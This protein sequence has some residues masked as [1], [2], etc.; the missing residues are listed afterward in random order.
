MILIR[1]ARVLTMIGP[2]SPPPGVA[3]RGRAMSDLGVLPRA[4]VM[5]EGDRILSVTPGPGSAPGAASRASGR[6]INAAGRVLM[7]GFIDAHTHALWAGDRLDEWE[8]KR[9][10]A[11][12]LDILKA[13]GGIMATVRAV[14]AASEDELA[15]GLRARLA[16]MLR[17]GTTTV[18]VKTGYGLSAEAELKMLRV[19]LGAARHAVTGGS[20]MPSA[21]DE[22]RAPGETRVE[23]GPR[24]M[25]SPAVGRPGCGAGAA[26]P[27][28]VP[29]ALLGHAIDPGRDR[30]EFIDEMC[31]PALDAAHREAP[32]AAVDA[33]CE[34]GAWTMDECVRLFERAASLGHPVRVH[35]D[36][37]HALGMT[38][39]AVDHGAR[40][41]DHLEAST[42][43]TLARLGR[44]ATIG[45]ALPCAGFHT[46]GRY[47]NARAII[48][49]G[50][51]VVLATN[52][53]PGSAPCASMP[54]AIALAV[55]HCGLSPAEAIVACSANA[56][57]LLGFADRGV[58]APGM[59]ADMILL[60]HDD[61]RLLACEF[62]G[63]PV[64]LV[65]RGGEIIGHQPG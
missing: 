44:S 6:V 21:P 56:A 38:D 42:P 57:A 34:D 13:G 26:L 39:W 62:G 28:V 15:R 23:S 32:H 11:S 27:A 7:P 24:T 17:E 54:M 33:Y 64:D 41:A 3:R 45:V 36:Q 49:A 53:N 37:F 10:G 4:D 12:Y 40:S 22:A 63:N 59:R 29:T 50:G 60:R 25:L 18:E 43:G 48:D 16:V 47:A 65:I 19:I 5:I 8:L 51:A 9:R 61:E 20:A 31:G 1:E 46:D 14:R 2:G 58:V 30:A 52:L 35:T 55:R